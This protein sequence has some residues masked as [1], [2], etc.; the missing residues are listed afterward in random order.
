LGNFVNRWQK[1]VS[2]DFERKVPAA[3]KVESL[4]TE[5]LAKLD[6]LPGEVGDD[7]EATR[8]KAALGRI[9][10]AFRD[11][12]RY[13]DTLAGTASVFEATIN[14]EIWSGGKLLGTKLI[15]A[16]AGAPAAGDWRVHVHRVISCSLTRTGS[17]SHHSINSAGFVMSA[18]GRV[19]PQ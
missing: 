18:R 5:L 16:S 1:I 9:M 10:E 6:R 17:R 7:I 4:E 3:T 15:T 11:C 13:I 12:N 2:D 14:M 8:F 19:T